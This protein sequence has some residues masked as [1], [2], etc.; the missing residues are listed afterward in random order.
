MSKLDVMPQKSTDTQ[1]GGFVEQ[2]AQRIQATPPGTCPIAVQYSLLE[3]SGVQTCGKCV[4]CRDGIPQLAQ[5]LKKVMD[6]KAT[7]ADL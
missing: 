7:P 4:P 1:I 5:L 6:C 2:F 3:S